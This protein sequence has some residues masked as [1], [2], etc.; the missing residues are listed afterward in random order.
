MEL[1]VEMADVVIY[2]GLGLALYAF[3]TWRGFVSVHGEITALRESIFTIIER[4]GGAIRALEEDVAV[5]IEALEEEREV[6]DNLCLETERYEEAKQVL[7]AA[8]DRCRRV[9]SGT[10]STCLKASRDGEDDVRRHELLLQSAHRKAEDAV[11]RARERNASVLLLANEEVE[12]ALGSFY[13]HNTRLQCA[14]RIHQRSLEAEALVMEV[15]A[16]GSTTNHADMYAGQ[17][18]SIEVQT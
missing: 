18:D 12:E 5:Q 16:H 6:I 3:I 1:A 13:A 11:A 15:S 17:L 8:G 10:Y 9:R 14:H 2:G 4:F 7:I